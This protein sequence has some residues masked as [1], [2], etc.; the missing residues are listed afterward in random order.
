M[1]KITNM[2]DVR[3]KS[4]HTHKRVLALIL[5]IVSSL[6]LSACQQEKVLGQELIEQAKEDFESLDSG[7]ITVTNLETNTIEQELEFKYDEVGLLIYAIQGESIDDKY[8]QYNNGYQFYTINK[9]EY[10]LIKKG[11]RE[12]QAYTKDVKYPQL[13][14]RYLYF[15]ETKI[16]ETTT[17]QTETTDVFEYDY[18]ASQIS[19]ENA[20]GQ[21]ESFKVVYTF[22]KD[23]EMM[24]FDEISIYKNNGKNDEYHYRIEITEKNSITKVEIPQDIK[25]KIEE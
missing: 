8:C 17:S 19:G 2:R 7:K 4:K 11:D 20:L 13:S 22:N 21:L 14:A 5:L 9:D 24:H 25:S 3:K 6:A 16:S 23:G 18:I 10:K 12:F 1:M 15:D